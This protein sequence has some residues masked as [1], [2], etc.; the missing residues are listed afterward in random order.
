[1]PSPAA[2]LTAAPREVAA[3]LTPA[4]VA[5]ARE[6]VARDILLGGRTVEGLAGYLGELFER[7]GRPEAGQDFLRQ[8]DGVDVEAV[9]GVIDAF[10]SGTP[11]LEVV[12]P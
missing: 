8:L 12:R 11:V 9:G 7:T 2:M 10:R 3:L 1:M 6:A 4:W 5:E